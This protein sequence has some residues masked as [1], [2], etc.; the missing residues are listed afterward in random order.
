MPASAKYVDSAHG[1]HSKLCSLSAYLPELQI[2][3]DSLPRSFAN[4]PLGQALH[5]VSAVG[6]HSEIMNSP[7][8][9]V[10][11]GLHTRSTVE[12]HSETMNCPAVHAVQGAHAF[13]LRC[14]CSK[15]LYVLG[16]QALHVDSLN[17]YPALHDAHLTSDEPKHFFPLTGVPLL[18]VQG[19]TSL[20]SDCF[21][22]FVSP[23]VEVLAGQGC[24]PSLVPAQYQSAGHGVLQSVSS[25]PLLVLPAGQKPGQPIN[26]S[27]TKEA[28]LCV[29]L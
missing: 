19:K 23:R 9:Q 17:S 28:E 3:Q 11:Q 10:E 22:L 16:S 2:L 6:V 26:P 27:F 18:H 8:V 12:L 4:L 7:G 14:M 20:Q 21:V 24:V 13:M 5:A 1:L 25:R 15:V 29:D